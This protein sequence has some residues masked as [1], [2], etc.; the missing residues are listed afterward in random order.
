MMAKAPGYFRFVGGLLLEDGKKAGVSLSAMDVMPDGRYHTIG[1]DLSRQ[2][3]WGKGILTNW[4]L[5]W[6]GDK[7]EIGLNA[8]RT[9]R[10]G[11]KIIG[12][13]SLVP[14]KE[15]AIPG[16]VLPRAHSLFRWEGGRCN[17]AT[18]RFY[19]RDGKELPNTS[20][21]IGADHPS[22]TFTTPE[23][24]IQATVE[25]A[26]GG[27]GYPV[28]QVL[29]YTKR[30]AESGTWRGQ[31]IWSQKEE[32]PNDARIWFRREL[33]LDAEPAYGAIAMQADDVGTL[34]V[35]GKEAGKTR[36]WNLP[37]YFDVTALLQKG[38]NIVD[39]CVYNGSM[40]GGLS[41]DVYVQ[42]RNG[43]IY[44]DTDRRWT[45]DPKSNAS[46]HIPTIIAQPVVELGL[47]AVTAPWKNG[48]GY[49]HAGPRGLLEILSSKP[50]EIQA[51]VLQL[52]PKRVERIHFRLVR[53]GLRDYEMNISIQPSSAEWKKDSVVTLTYGVPYVEKGK[54]ALF[55][56]DDYI[57]V[58]TPLRP[59]AEWTV[60]ARPTSPLQEARFVN[61]P[62]TMIELGGQRFSPIFWHTVTAVRSKKYH[63]FQM[64][65]DYGFRNFRVMTDF[66]DFWLGPGQFDFTAFD[67]L[68]TEILTVCPDGI[69]NL[70]IYA[71][72]PD[73]WIRKYPDEMAAKYGNAPRRIDREYQTLTSRKWVE[74]AREPLE[75]LIRHV[76][77]KPY[78]GQFWGATVC[79]NGNGEWFWNNQD[80]LG[81][82][83]WGGYAVA[84]IVNFR[85]YLQEKY[86]TDT[87]LAKAW[88]HPGMTFAQAELCPPAAA[89][90][91]GCGELYISPDEQ[92]VMD[93]IDYR[94]VALGQAICGFGKHIKEL[95]NGK[96][97]FGVYYGY[98]T[99]LLGNSGGRPIQLSGHTA[100]LEVAKSPY[101]DFVHGPSR[102]TFRRVGMADGLMQPWNTFTMRGKTVYI[103]GDYRYGYGPIET[104]PYYQNYI[105]SPAS[106]FRSL[107]QMYRAFGMMLATG[108]PLY[109][110]DISGGALYE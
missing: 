92:N 72:M 40:N 46:G 86:G 61:A 83:S 100:F 71:H 8:F 48:I 2:P 96:W 76:K 106:G 17:G 101:V 42:M 35:N 82:R 67:N 80:A 59:V 49:R 21:S 44:A 16:L 45:C 69:F 23:M 87:A 5:R 60:S 4:E 110:F 97:L 1:F 14:G 13:P 6:F 19:G 34:Y 15:H 50:G 12:A 39:V 94:S 24:L 51:K 53:E 31:W 108:C 28:F 10:I 98:F 37:G 33:D 81:R 7:G 38:H 103:E 56:A 65:F 79:E 75:A 104:T 47:P 107:G 63:E 88:N 77:S 55:V 18:L 105:G 84:D 54:A 25:I 109:W 26:A 30:F 58:T 57:G 29:D 93:W 90:K 20:V 99:E 89:D 3:N 41:A 74:D 91:A 73:W 95:T 43:E 9:Q 64:G 36:Q 11:N 70:H 68:M 22:A 85:K 66:H 52:P 102:Y 27:D 32:G 78:A 62:H